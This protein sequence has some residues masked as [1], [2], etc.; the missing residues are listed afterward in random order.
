M[1]Y[2]L[3]NDLSMFYK[4]FEAYADHASPTNGW[5][6]CIYRDSRLGTGDMPHGWAAA[7]YILLHR[8][9]MVY[10]NGNDLELC[11]GVAPKWL[12]G[13]ARVWVKDAPTKFGTT[14]FD[15]RRSASVLTLEHSVNPNP[16]QPKPSAVRLHIPPLLRNEITTV[17]VNGRAYTLFPEESVVRID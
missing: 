7:S 16:N 17:R 10:E 3:G 6:E 11:W 1:C 5:P 4:L 8:N 2:L 14:N 13:D 15:L 9:S 12:V